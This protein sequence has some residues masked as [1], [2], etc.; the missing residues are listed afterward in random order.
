MSSSAMYAVMVYL[1]DSEI[2]FSVRNELVT[3]R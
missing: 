1:L 3:L 2:N